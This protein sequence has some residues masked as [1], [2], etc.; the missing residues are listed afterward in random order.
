[1]DNVLS[2]SCQGEKK[3]KTK[4]TLLSMWYRL[5]T[6]NGNTAKTASFWPV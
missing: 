6:I 2:K 1:M 4:K 3:T 5:G